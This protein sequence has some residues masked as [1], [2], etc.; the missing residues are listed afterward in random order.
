MPNNNVSLWSPDKTIKDLIWDDLVRAS[1]YAKGKLLDVG[2]GNKP[3]LTIFKDCVDLYIGL[4]RNSNFADIKEDFFNANIKNSNFDTILATQVLEHVDSPEKFLKK[5]NKILKKDGVLIITAPF[6]GSLHEIPNDY[7]RFTRYGLQVLLKKSGFEILYLKEQGNWFL[8]I[9][10]LINFYLEST[11]NRF[12]LRYPKKIL[13]LLIQSF[14]QVLSLFPKRF[15]KPE[16]CPINYIVV[17][18]KM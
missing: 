4:D 10:S 9:S 16:Y 15:T 18:R 11:L 3:Y 13:Q 17:A 1:K 6:I 7:Y 14:F 5:A 12:F 8:S 2:C